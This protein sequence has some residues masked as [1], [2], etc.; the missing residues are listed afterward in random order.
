MN[1]SMKKLKKSYDLQ[2]FNCIILPVGYIMMKMI[3]INKDK[4]FK[5]FRRVVVVVVL[6]DLEVVTK[7]GGSGLVRKNV[8]QSYLI[9]KI[10]VNNNSIIKLKRLMKSCRKF[11]L[12]FVL[13]ILCYNYSNKK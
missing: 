4:R 8:L 11:D 2:L 6:V 9:R 10:I 12:F 7:F 5:I 1:E 13:L 3:M